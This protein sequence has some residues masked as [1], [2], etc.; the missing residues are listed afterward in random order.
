VKKSLNVNVLSTLEKG[1]VEYLFSNGT[2]F[3]EAKKQ[4][5][6]EILSIVEIDETSISESELLDISKSGDNNAVSLDVSCLPNKY[7]MGCFSME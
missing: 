6:S 1:R 7:R 4:A 3:S 2:G 5:Q